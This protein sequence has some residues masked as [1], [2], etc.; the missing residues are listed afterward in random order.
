MKDLILSALGEGIGAA[1]LFYPVTWFA[2]RR[3]LGLKKFGDS[4]FGFIAAILALPICKALGVFGQG[5]TQ[6]GAVFSF[7][8]PIALC[9]LLV[10]VTKPKTAA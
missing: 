3:Q 1:I 7:L 5:D 4:K 2:M 9:S 10:F 6:L 8:G